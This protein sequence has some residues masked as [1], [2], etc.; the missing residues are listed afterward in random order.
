MLT[1]TGL[2]R[3]VIY[4]N[5]K[6]MLKISVSPEEKRGNQLMLAWNGIGAA[7]VF[8]IDNDA[9]LTERIIG[10]R[11]LKTMAMNDRDEEATRIICQVADLLHLPEEKRTT[12]LIPL[13]VWFNDLL[14]S[15]GRYGGIFIESAKT[16]SAL[17]KEQKNK[18]VLHGDL[19]HD[20][21]LYSSERGWLAIDPKGLSGE[22]AFDYVNILC[23]PTKEIALSEDRLIEQINVISRNTGIEQKH[24]LKWT[25]AWAGLSAIWFLND[26]QDAS[27]PAGVAEM[28]LRVLNN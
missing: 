11:S 20:N 3:P 4:E 26:K 5:K 16:A 12:E 7:K 23:N 13:H 17:L 18:T 14:S 6:A 28:A 10:D 19:H 2:I 27:L 22:R 9:I 1:H 21:I 24:L 15:A 8:R 25:A